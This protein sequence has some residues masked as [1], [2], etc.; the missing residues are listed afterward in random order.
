[1]RL[2]T[3]AGMLIT[4]T[5]A[6][7]SVAEDWPNFL[8]PRHDLISL[9]TGLRTSWSGPIPRIWER[10]VG[11]ALS[12]ISVVGGRAYTYGEAGKRQV[13]YCLDA[14]TGEVIWQRDFEGAYRE[15][16][17]GDGTR[18]TPTVDGDRVYVLGALGRLICANANTGE[19]LWDRKFTAE[20]RWGYSGSVLIEGDLAILS[21]GKRAGALLA[22]DKRTGEERWRTGSE[23]AGYAT[24]YP[25]TMNDKRYVVGFVADA[26]LIVEAAT[27]REVWRTRWKTDWNVNAAAPIFHEDHLFLS[28]GYSTGSALFRLAPSGDKLAGEEVWRNNVIMNKFQ[29]SILWKGYLYTSDQNGL[30]CADF[31]TGEARWRMRRLPGSDAS[32]VDG[33][34]TM[35]DGNIYYLSQGGELAI[36]PASRAGFEPVTMERV[37]SGLCWTV[38]TIS[39]GRLYVRNLTHVVCIDLRP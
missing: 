35:A 7:T 16:Q 39:N 19:I 23:A 14:E 18:A 22:L 27:G 9:E 13:L 12:G 10:E 36:G 37:L 30:R 21:P 20:P 3:A 25:F 17:G 1:M 31:R 34:M 24:P 2:R 32:Q 15:S 28:S 5:I 38:P 8:G 11:S 29:S 6:G 26:A 4:L 33:T